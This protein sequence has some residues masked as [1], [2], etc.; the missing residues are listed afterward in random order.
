MPSS[1]HGWSHPGKWV[2]TLSN[3]AFAVI[4]H[5]ARFCFQSLVYNMAAVFY[6]YYSIICFDRK[7]V[8]KPVRSLT[9]TAIGGDNPSLS[10]D[11]R[12]GISQLLPLSRPPSVAVP[13][14]LCRSNFA[15][16]NVWSSGK[17]VKK[18]LAVAD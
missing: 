7:R 16:N 12:Q 1:K 8:R 11:L 10:G 4:G 3:I 18:L 14:Q 2:H 13:E 15:T 17:V 6:A 5:I 9:I